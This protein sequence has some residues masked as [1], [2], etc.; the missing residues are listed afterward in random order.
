MDVQRDS[1]PSLSFR[2]EAESLLKKRGVR[3]V[4][5]TLE[6]GGKKENLF[7]GF[8]D[9]G[10]PGGSEKRGCPGGVRNKGRDLTSVLTKAENEVLLHH[11]ITRYQ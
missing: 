2:P 8:L 6:Y 5:S 3:G 4:G 9:P 7:G 10:H 1:R 11:L